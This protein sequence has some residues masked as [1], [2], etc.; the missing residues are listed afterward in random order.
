MSYGNQYFDYSSHFTVD[1]GDDDE[2]A[3]WHHHHQP[4]LVEMSQPAVN[5]YQIYDQ[6]STY[7]LPRSYNSDRRY[8]NNN[9]HNNGVTMGMEPVVIQH[10]APTTSAQGL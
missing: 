5:P 4:H 1:N 6:S 2:I 7:D 8:H 10:V 3:L 9:R